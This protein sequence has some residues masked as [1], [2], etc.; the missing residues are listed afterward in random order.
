MEK[1]DTCRIWVVVRAWIGFFD[2]PSLFLQVTHTSPSFRHRCSL[3]D[4][5]NSDCMQ[6]PEIWSRDSLS[7]RRCVAV[8]A[9]IDIFQVA[10]SNPTAQVHCCSAVR[11]PHPKSHI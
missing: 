7:Y 10:Q 2:R 9:F 4:A 5:P 3:T 8:I 1:G 6:G 11:L